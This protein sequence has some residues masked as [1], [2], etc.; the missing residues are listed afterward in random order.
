[1]SSISRAEENYREAIAYGEQALK[2]FRALKDESGISGVYYS[3]GIYHYYLGDYGRAKDYMEACI[4][5]R[6]RL[7]SP[8]HIALIGPYE[9]LGIAHEESGDYEKTLFYLRKGL[10]IIV[11][12]YPTGS[13]RQGFNYENIALAF[14]SNKQLDSAL[15]YMQLAHT[16]LPQQLPKNDYSMAVHFFSYANILYQLDRLREAD[17]MLQKSNA[18]SARPSASTK[19]STRF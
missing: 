15:H 16:I 17:D 14:K 4:R 3:L 5:I 1:M 18:V 13:V 7:F 10:E 11:A 19:S 12:N 8:Q 6:E 2:I 9:V